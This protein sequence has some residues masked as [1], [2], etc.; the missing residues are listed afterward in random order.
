MLAASYMA[1]TVVL[2]DM[3]TVNIA[4]P[5]ISQEFG[6]DLSTVSWLLLVSMLTSSS[7]ALVAGKFID[8]FEPRKLFIIGFSAFGSLTFL[9]F[10]VKDVYL[11]IAI[12]FLQ[13]FAEALIYVIGPALIRRYLPREKQQ[14]AHGIWMMCTG[15]GISMG[16]LLGG[17]LVNHFSWNWVFLVNVPL[18][19]L[20]LL[21][22]LKMKKLGTGNNNEDKA[23]FDRAGAVLSFVFLS[24]LIYGLNTLGRKSELS[25]NVV[26]PLLLSGIA[27][28]LFIH[29]EKEQQNPVFDFRLF[30][31]RQFLLSNSGFFLFF[32]VNVGSRFLRPFYF[33]E[34]QG[35]TST[36]SGMLMTVSPLLMMVVSPLAKYLS[37][38]SRPALIFVGGNLFLAVSM[39][40]FAS[41][42][43]GTSVYFLVFSMIVL[44]IGMGL[45]Y[46]T[47]SYIGMLSLPEGKQGMGSAAIST[48]KS[49]GKL[50]GV[51]LFGL[52][53]TFF[54]PESFVAELQINAFQN[55][56]LAGG[57]I[58]VISLFLS[59]RILKIK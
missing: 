56:F 23:D 42:D 14:S 35:L 15:I 5:A 27:L 39:F 44:G 30:G 25:W 33:E 10:L 21:F 48:S 34:V 19:F 54:V 37:D 3:T 57:F 36:E 46:P 8:L 49:L 38:K 24:G 7:V 12:R 53:F 59:L 13:G 2:M 17:L 1:A 9:S 6:I 58:A 11:I 20:G 4:L 55:T 43:A 16:P 31:I 28:L 45:F 18:T 51:L 41:W 47:S 29:R 26:L 40:M 22:A 50:S 52:I 32:L